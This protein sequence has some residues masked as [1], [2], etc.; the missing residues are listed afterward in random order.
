MVTIGKELDVNIGYS[1]HTIGIEVN[2]AAVAMGAKCIEKHF[3]LDSKMS[4]PDHKASL[5]PK[6]LK[7]MIESI[8]KI[9]IALG[10]SIKQPSKSEILNIQTIRKS[11][12]AKIN[13][14]K[15]DIF[16]E[17]NLAIKRPGAGIS[18]MKWDKIIGTKA[19]K[20]YEE[21]DLI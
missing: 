19:S 4:G 8:R 18:P 2:I 15:G 13:I 1:D 21:D 9:E 14:K 5:E 17:N 6:Q 11:I 3:T 12:V 10:S 16:N 20:N 7:A